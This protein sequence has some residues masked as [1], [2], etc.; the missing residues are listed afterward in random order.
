MSSETNDITEELRKSLLLNY[1]EGLEESVRGSKFA[2]DS[3]DL[4][5]YH[6]HRISLKRDISYIKSSKWLKNKKT[7]INPKDE[8]D[9]NCFQY[10]VTV[11]LD[12]KNIGENPHK[13]S[14]TKPFINS[15][16]WKGTDF[17]SH[18][19]YWKKLEQSNKT[20]ALNILYVPYSNKQIELAYKSKHY[21]QRENQVISLLVTDGK[22]WHYLVLKSLPTFDGKK[23]A[24]F[25]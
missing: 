4:L 2:C 20:I 17:P 15:D 23:G 13:I 22:K 19:K 21:F 6:L 7:T 11:E 10:A 25:L 9:D 3:I 12:H 14:S 8:G 18:S 16:D 5:Y 1:H 24:I